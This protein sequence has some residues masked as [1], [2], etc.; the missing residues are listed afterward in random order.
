MFKNT[1]IM[2]GTIITNTVVKQNPVCLFQYIKQPQIQTK[3]GRRNGLKVIVR[4][5]LSCSKKIN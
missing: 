3:Q 2:Y 5:R 1:V 4:M